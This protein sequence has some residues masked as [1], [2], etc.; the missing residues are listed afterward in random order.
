VVQWSWT[1]PSSNFLR[2]VLYLEYR[3]P[4]EF[5]GKFG[6]QEAMLEMS[7]F[8]HWSNNSRNTRLE[9]IHRPVLSSSVWDV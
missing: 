2:T 3:I 8:V 6:G 7:K 9:E 1:L 5:R 4:I